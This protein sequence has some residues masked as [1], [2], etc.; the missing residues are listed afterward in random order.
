MVMDENK[1]DEQLLF[2]L[3]E[4]N[5]FNFEADPKAKKFKKCLEDIIIMEGIKL[6]D[7][8]TNTEGNSEIF[9]E[10]FDKLDSRLR[11]K[12]GTS[13][14]MISKTKKRGDEENTTKVSW[15]KGTVVAFLLA[16]V[17]VFEASVG[18]SQGMVITAAPLCAYL[19][20]KKF[21]R[22]EV[23]DELKKLNGRK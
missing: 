23:I 8:K 20:S 18:N 6:E 17:F 11:A 15:D 14:G 12:K 10:I 21:N 19:G 2:Y 1:F 22:D 9:K 5:E 3:N 4:L 16:A 13:L 7:I